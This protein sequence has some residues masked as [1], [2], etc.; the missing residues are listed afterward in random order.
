MKNVHMPREQLY[1]PKESSLSTPLNYFDVVC[2]TK[3]SLDS[4]E[5]SRID[6][7][8]NMDGNR[9]LSD[10]WSRSTIFRVLNKRPLRGVSLVHVRLTNI[11]SQI[12]TRN[13]LAR[14][15]VKCA[16]KKARLQRKTETQEH[17]LHVRSGKHDFL[18][19]D[20]ETPIFRTPERSWRFHRDT[21]CHT[22]HKHTSAPPRHRR[23]KLQCQK[24]ARRRPGIQRM[25]N[26]DSI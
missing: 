6:D 5:G 12:E 26:G 8:W 14:S 13:E 17:K 11:S 7:L 25:A 21:L 16:P 2:Q 4:L 9:V 22:L 15:V 18:P 23:K 20:F 19:D 24:K 10:S 1:V 3:T